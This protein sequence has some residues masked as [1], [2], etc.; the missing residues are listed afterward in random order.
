MFMLSFFLPVWVPNMYMT[1]FSFLIFP[2]PIQIAN[3]S[4]KLRC[5]STVTEL[6]YPSQTVKPCRNINRPFY[7]P[8]MLA[9]HLYNLLDKSGIVK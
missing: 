1:K 3:I 6:Y 7:T 5:E 9:L 2:L 8:K 4:Y